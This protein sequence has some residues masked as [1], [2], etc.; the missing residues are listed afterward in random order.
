MTKINVTSDVFNI[1]LPIKFGFADWGSFGE[2]G[3]VLGKTTK[4]YIGLFNL[5]FLK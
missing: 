4:M 5:Y 2:F 3:E 1:K